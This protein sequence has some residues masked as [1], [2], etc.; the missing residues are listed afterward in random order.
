MA[1]LRCLNAI[2]A[3]L[4]WHSYNACLKCVKIFLDN[5]K[6]ALFY[7]YT[8]G[9]KMVVPTRTMVERHSTAIG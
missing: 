2:L 4:K 9:P 7:Q 3:T 1:F 5:T 6:N 8:R